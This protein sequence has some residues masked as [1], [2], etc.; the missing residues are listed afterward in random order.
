VLKANLGG[1]L[2][3]QEVG[4]ESLVGNQYFLTQQVRPTPTYVKSLENMVFKAFNVG[5]E[6]VRKTVVAVA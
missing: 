1:A 2:T 3:A 4:S 6:V 5:R